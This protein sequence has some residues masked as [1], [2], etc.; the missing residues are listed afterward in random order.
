M[1]YIFYNETWGTVCDDSFDNIDAQ[2]ACRQLGYNNGIFAGSTTKSVE[3]QMWLDNVDCSGDENK[4]ADC[5]H[6][7]W[8]VEDCFRGEHVKIKCNNN[9]EGDVRLSSGKLEILHNNEWGTVCSDNFDKIEAQVACNQLGYSYGSVLEKTVATST[10]RIWL[11]E[12][13]CNGGETKLSDCSHTDWGK[14][15]CSHGNI[16]GIRCFEGNGV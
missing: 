5:T 14:H 8:G 7:G 2:V 15:T 16:V 12:L 11:S 10:L 6:S 3:K 9:T 13:R 1:I 4:L